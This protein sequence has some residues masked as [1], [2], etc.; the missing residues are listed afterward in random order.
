MRVLI[1]E[2][3][4]AEGKAY[5]KERGFDLIL[6]SAAD[7]ATLMREIR[8]MDGAIVRTAPFTKKIIAAGDRL[9]VISK[10]GVGVENIDVEAASAAGIRVTN[11][12]LSNAN[13]VAEHTL[14]LMLTL[15]KQLALC[16][17][18]VRSGDFAIRNR[19]VLDDLAGKTVGIIG[20]G[21]IGRRVAE[22]C[23]YG[24]SMRVLAYNRSEKEMPD[25]VTPVSLDTL[26]SSADYIS[27]HIPL[28][29]E[30]RK[31]ID[32]AAL[33]KIKPSAYLINVA[34][35]DVVDTDA[36]IYALKNK[37]I[38]GAGIDVF[39][40]EPP[41]QN[42]PFFTL[43]NV[44]LSPH[45]AAHTKKAFSDMSLHA[46]IGVVEVLEGLPVTWPIN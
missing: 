18:A 26:L 33:S 23:H 38:K 14:A 17:K 20:F 46:A 29:Q 44:V 35:A 6:A 41:L 24:F 11:G 3:I 8:S 27:L 5:L 45:N 9:K 40:P 7:E 21:N 43:P 1:T 2:D 32:A 28:T 16:D 39:S 22:K 30:T 4:A 19:I 15:T 42:N 12:P 37:K 10:H 34:R 36:L 25:Y 13:S 31:L